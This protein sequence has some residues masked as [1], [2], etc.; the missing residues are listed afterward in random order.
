MSEQIEKIKGSIEY[1]KYENTE[2]EFSIL[3]ILCNEELLT[4]TG[5]MIGIKQ[6]EDIEFY[7]KFSNHPVYGIQFNADYFIRRMPSNVSGVLKYLSSGVIKGIGEIMAKRIVEMFG[8]ETLD[9]LKGDKEKLCKVKGISPK[10]AEDIINN[11][12]NIFGANLVMT[13]LQGYSINNAVALKIYKIYGEKSIDK[14]KENP[15]I[16][17]MDDVG[18]DFDV[19]DILGEKYFIEKTDYKRVS[20]GVIYTLIHNIKNG[21]T[22]IPCQKLCKVLQSF[23]EVE[24]FIIES[25]INRC[26]E[27]NRLYLDTIKN[28]DCIYLPDMYF[29]ERYISS[30]MALA[31]NSNIVDNSFN[32]DET[33]EVYNS[34][35]LIKYNEK[36]KDAI[37][38]AIKNN[39]MLLTGGPGTGKTTT[40]NA[41]VEVLEKMSLN[42]GFCAPTGRAAQRME[43][44]TGREAKTIHRLLEVDYSKDDEKIKFIRN[45]KNLLKQDVIIVDEISMVDVFLFS[46][47]LKAIKLNCKLILVGDYNQLPSVGAGNVLKDIIDSE[48]VLTVKLEEIFR[49]A[50][51]SLIIRNSHKIISGQMPILDDNKSDF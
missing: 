6:G 33:V 27:E 2:S 29:D 10:K 51:K 19:C 41:I 4:V 47:L 37:K 21:H 5:K 35:S 34:N 49:Q 23:L 13:F 30:R 3:E 50:A 31:I 38:M 28:V 32:T 12:N 36:Q 46:S 39:I 16:L 26:V 8:E 45:E 42:V 1:V 15:Y 44:V 43:K 20:A 14:I 9:I 25:A 40:I 7:G 17:C 48:V 18:V 22:C 11:Y 24:I